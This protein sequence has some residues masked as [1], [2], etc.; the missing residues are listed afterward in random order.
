MVFTPS[1]SPSPYMPRIGDVAR[2]GCSPEPPGLAERP[3]Y[4]HCGSRHQTSPPA[5][6][7]RSRLQFRPARVMDV[8]TAVITAKGETIMTSTAE[9][10]TT[11]AITPAGAQA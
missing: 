7:F 9:S 3:E 1:R 4:A 6:P 5:R 2:D 8:V 10:G 11:P